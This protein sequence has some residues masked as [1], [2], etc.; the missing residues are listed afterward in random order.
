MTDCHPAAFFDPVP[1]RVSER[2][3]VANSNKRKLEYYDLANTDLNMSQK[4]W[5][6]NGLDGKNHDDPRW[7]SLDITSARDFKDR[8]GITKQRIQHWRKRMKFGLP[9]LE[10]SGGVTA[11]SSLEREKIAS[12][13]IQLRADKKPVDDS[14][15]RNAFIFGRAK[16]FLQRKRWITIRCGRYSA[17]V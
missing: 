13:V 9:L 14:G 16:K 7:Q 4:T 5:V 17:S 6:V 1:N 8:Y 12:K 10:S 15:L 3:A 11:L 2:V